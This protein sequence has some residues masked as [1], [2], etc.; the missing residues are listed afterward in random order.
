M[1]DEPNHL[2]LV[3]DG[4]ERPDLL[5]TVEDGTL[6]IENP[7]ANML[8]VTDFHGTPSGLTVSDDGSLLNWLG[9]N[10][11]RQSERLE[12]DEEIARLKKAYAELLQARETIDPTAEFTYERDRM[13]AV[14]L[15]EAMLAGAGF[16]MLR[17]GADGSGAMFLQK[18]ESRPGVQVF[19]QVPEGILAAGPANVFAYVKANVGVAL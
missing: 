17:D 16:E 7:K 3:V 15:V 13:E 5:A 19:L 9:E 18:L 11:V 4:Q 6:T 14:E 1:T 8:Q 12:R 2:R 10:F